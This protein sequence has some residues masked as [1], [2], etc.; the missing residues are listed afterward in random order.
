MRRIQRFP[1][2]AALAAIIVLESALPVWAH[3]PGVHVHGR[4]TLEI[5]IDGAT[6]QVNLNSPLDN[7][8][9]FEHAPRN[10][11][12]H[13]AVTA[14]TSKFNQADSLFIFTPAAQC[15]VEST[16]LTSPVLSPDLLV[17]A[18]DSGKSAD[19][20]TR[21]YSGAS[22]TTPSTP[23]PAADM[24]AELEATWQFRCAQPQ[25]LQGV[26]V[27][28]FQM[29]PGLQRLDAAV[30]GP[31]GQSSAKLSPESTRLKW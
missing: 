3:E 12:E 4:A 23:S 14:M 22:R 5:A 8:L 13:Q 2:Q 10:E 15:R 25:A 18:S 9:R 28:L 21:K 19:K 6:V 29:F 30:A 26:D 17:P 24:H 27:R 16:D 1:G 31:K 11:K 7:L 20:S